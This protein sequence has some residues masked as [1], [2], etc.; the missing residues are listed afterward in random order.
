LYITTQTKAVFTPEE[1]Q[2]FAAQY[3]AQQAALDQ[4]KAD[5]DGKIVFDVTKVN[6][7]QQK[8]LGDELWNALNKRTYNILYKFKTARIGMNAQSVAH[9]MI[10]LFILIGNI[11]YFLTKKNEKK[12]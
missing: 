1:Y 8:A 11:G 7:D 10:F 5:E 4:L 9:V 6:A 2:K 12:A 3:P